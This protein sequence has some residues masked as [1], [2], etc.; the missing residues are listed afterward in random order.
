M[1]C[2]WDVNLF[3]YLSLTQLAFN[4]TCL[5][6]VMAK[7]HRCL[8]ETDIIF[9][10]TLR[11]PALAWQGIFLYRVSFNHNGKLNWIEIKM[12]FSI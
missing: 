12:Y 4:L 3:A 5:I 6:V 7:L 9:C 2:Y 10:T 1:A 11:A 8:F